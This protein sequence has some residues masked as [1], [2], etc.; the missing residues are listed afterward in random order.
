MEKSLQCVFPLDQ[1]VVITIL[2]WGH[3]WYCL[4][5]NVVVVVI[6]AIVDD[7]VVCCSG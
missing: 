4:V 2:Q 5:V 7:L 3:H 6:V 1:T